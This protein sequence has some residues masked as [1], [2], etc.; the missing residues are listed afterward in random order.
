[1]ILIPPT[2]FALFCLIF[3]SWRCDMGEHGSYIHGSAF[4]DLSLFPH[5][6][7]SIVIPQSI[8]VDPNPAPPRGSHTPSGAFILSLGVRP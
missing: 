6:I 8:S 3:R 5:R 1:M 7:R 2:A 4:S